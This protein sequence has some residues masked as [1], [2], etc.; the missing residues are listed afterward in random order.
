MENDIKKILSEMTLEEKVALCSGLD[1]F[2][3][4]G[5]ERLNVP[6]ILLSDGPHG[7]RKQ[8]EQADFLGIHD[9]VKATCFPTAA[10]LACSFDTDLMHQV[11]KALGEECKTEGVSVLLGPGVNIKRSPLCGRN[12]EYFSEDPYLTSK[13]AS[14]YICGVQSEEVGTS[15]KHYA[16]NN[17]EDNRLS[18]NVLVDQRTLREI[19]LSSFEAAIQEA[20]PWTVMCAY[21]KVNGYFCS[22][23]K[24]LLNDILREEWGFE[25]VVVSDWGAVAHRVEALNAGLDLEMPSSGTLSDKKLLAALESGALDIKTLDETAERLLKLIHK[26]SEGAV[27]RI[28]FSYDAEKHHH[29]AKQA[30]IE[31][32]VLLKNE[33][34]ILPLRQNAKIAVIGEMAQ[35]PRYQG[36]GSSHVN[37]TKLD[38][39][40][41]ILKAEAPEAAYAKG[42][43]RYK[44]TEDE[45]LI[46]EAKKLA[47]NVECAIVFAGLTE[48]YESE[49]YDRKHLRMPASHNRL[50]EEVAS[51]QPNTV[52]VLCNGAPVEMPWLKRIKGLLEA[53][54]GGQA[55]GGAISDLLF[56]KANPCGKLAET[57]PMKLSHNPSYLN[58][59]G[60]GSQVK[61]REGLFIGYRYYDKKEIEPLFPF[62]YGL[63][64]TNFEYSC[65]TSDRAQMTDQDT[66]K[67]S[68]RVKNIGQLGGK[69]IIQLY[70]RKPESKMI[71]AYKE[72]KGFN[73]IWLNPGEEK[74]VSFELDK[75][76]F[77]YY[78]VKVNDW[79]VESGEYEVM[80]A[81]SS[82]DI[83][84][85][86]RIHVESTARIKQVYDRY[87]TVGEIMDDPNQQEIAQELIDLLS[88]KGAILYNLRDNIEMA[89]GMVRGMGLCSLYGASNATFDEDRLQAILS[90]LNK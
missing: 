12:F 53:Y 47:Q 56:G 35:I 37:A 3:L 77:A 62:G 69:E 86:K 33:D 73:K 70:V 8:D 26:A 67:V 90:R 7:L 5:I 79:I 55:L 44:D 81:K 30:A 28:E 63:S 65:M 46:S 54:L 52:V 71:R 31:S 49:G 68:V 9:S 59:P 2:H 58:F 78:N 19:Y 10:T 57:F 24:Q 85:I 48:D 61:Y 83:C 16:A 39:I 88:M 15:I 72:L 51:V 36:A 13:L 34:Q 76:A 87:S 27:N 66:L 80:I 14:G 84:L 22:E 18:V 75:R 89:Y 6:S 74:E 4:K 21:N 41:E 20:K 17:Q 40:F 50:I 38:N 32:M 82:K 64:Y 23:Q 45:N 25:G 1:F 29:I 43:D 42:Y 11:G 60:E